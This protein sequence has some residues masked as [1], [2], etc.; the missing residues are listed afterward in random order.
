MRLS[1]QSGVFM[2]VTSVPG[3]HGIGDLGDGARAFVDFLAD[4]EQSMW[5]FCPLGPT[6]PAM[7]NSPYQSTSSFA[8]NPLLIDLTDLAERGWLIDDDLEPV[9]DFDPHAVDYERVGRQRAQVMILY[10][11]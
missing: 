8:G 6:E 7:A 11:A 9:P 4:A 2:H 5:Q 1:R 10:T 3:P